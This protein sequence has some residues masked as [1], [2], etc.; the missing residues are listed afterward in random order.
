MSKSNKNNFPSLQE[1]VSGK[2]V[3]K[4]VE[5]GC[6]IQESEQIQLVLDIMR[7]PVPAEHIGDAIKDKPQ[8]QPK[9]VYPDSSFQSLIEAT[10]NSTKECT[11]LFLK[12]LFSGGHRY[13]NLFLKNFF[14]ELTAQSKFKAN[15]IA[16]SG[17]RDLVYDPNRF[18]GTFHMFIPDKHLAE[19]GS[20][21]EPDCADKPYIKDVQIKLLTD[22]IKRNELYLSI[23]RVVDVEILNSRGFYSVI[24]QLFGTSTEPWEYKSA[25]WLFSLLTQ[26]IGFDDQP[27]LDK[28]GLMYECMVRNQVSNMPFESVIGHSDSKDNP[29]KLIDRLEMVGEISGQLFEAYVNIFDENSRITPQLHDYHKMKRK[30][31]KMELEVARALSDLKAERKTVEQIRQERK[32][33]ESQT[34]AKV[35]AEH[36][37]ELRKIEGLKKSIDDLESRLQYEKT[38]ACQLNVSL[39]AARDQIRTLQYQLTQ[40]EERIEEYEL[41]KRST[42]SG[43]KYEIYLH[44]NIK[45]ETSFSYIVERAKR[46]LAVDAGTVKPVQ[47]S[48][49]D[50]RFY[51]R[52]RRDFPEFTDFYKYRIGQ[53]RLVFTLD[54]LNAQIIKI[55]K[56]HSEYDNYWKS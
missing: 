24:D 29:D 48:G 52:L 6:N 1:L 37:A 28:L 55:W 56:S 22:L 11:D 27:D 14:R 15:E 7:L 51:N 32:R 13:S 8:N 43:N 16:S 25:R 31:E 34:K 38:S 17:L 33:Y 23:T 9:Q 47:Q 20:H 3:Q 2:S 18:Y 5:P 46:F 44:P 36:K 42:E 41:E 19:L 35:A 49:N 45:D 39:A 10:Y 54:G 26:H 21:D 12:K 53:S 30:F 40:A 4:W 50:V